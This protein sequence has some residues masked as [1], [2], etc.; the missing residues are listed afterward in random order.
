MKKI[1]ALLLA[2][3][4]IFS[5]SIFLFSCNDT[6]IVEPPEPPIPED[7]E[8]APDA[9]VL[10]VPEY[11]DYLRG[12]VDFDALVYTRPDFEGAV[13]LFLELTKTVEDNLIP[14]EEQISRILEADKF[15]TEIVSMRTLA[16][17]YTSKDSSDEY[18]AEEYEYI[19][20]GYPEFAQSIEKLFVASAKSPHRTRFETDCFGGSLEDYLDG[21]IYTDECVSLM[22]E[23]AALEAEYSALS[24][25]TVYITYK[26]KTDT[27][28]NIV[29]EYLAAYGENSQL[30]LTA[31]SLCDALYK[32]EYNK[33]SVELFVE[34]LKVRK[35]ISDTLG[36]ESY[37]KHAYDTIY[38]DYSPE[39]FD[40]LVE[41]VT[42]YVIPVYVKLSNYVFRPYISDFKASSGAASK[43]EEITLLNTMY[44][45]FSKTDSELGE[46]YSYMLQHKLYDVSEKN[47]NRF[48]GSFTS[49]VEDNSSPFLFVTLKGDAGDYM[50]LSHEFGHFFDMY[51]NYNET[52]SLDFAEISS[53]S[54]ELLALGK[55]EELF[56]KDTYKYIYYLE[57]DSL[58][59]TII[60][61]TFYA[62]IEIAAYELDY[63]EINVENLN[64]IVKK[65]AEKFSLSSSVNSISS[66]MI[67]HLMLYPFYVQS[68]ATSMTVSAQ[69]YCMEQENAGAGFAVYKELTDRNGDL[70]FEE[71]VIEAGLKS[72]FEENTLKEIADKI[73]Y[74]LYGAH[75]F[76]YSGGNVA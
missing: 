23:E 31:K 46:A 49:Y 54:L 73:H 52:G 30:Y 35:K 48:S 17:I 74:E 68:Y 25:K 43:T 39:K 16:H 12:T 4:L 1:I 41:E 65:T 75:Y 44:E 11:K 27:Y 18:W 71:S 33:R 21:G 2:F 32:V 64:N 24:T 26:G 15:Y 37:E 60:F 76:T 22:A 19:S 13:N 9:P 38:H 20:T 47:P 66:V 58:F 3:I 28:E 8:E 72:P 67:P 59:S 6:G 63:D 61:Q 34:L 53:Q 57:L 55:M 62:A 42:S 70:S 56:D 14:I 45:L 51:I 40:A 36:Y 69:I 29:G 10:F 50:T 5:N 7:E